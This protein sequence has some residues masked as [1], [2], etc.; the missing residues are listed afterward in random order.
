MQFKGRFG[1]SSEPSTTTLRRGLPRRLHSYSI[2]SM[3]RAIG[4][5]KFPPFR[6]FR[7]GFEPVPDKPVDLAEVHL[8]TGVNGT[9]KTRIL[10]ALAALLGNPEPLQKRLSEP[11]QQIDLAIAANPR[12]DAVS[13]WPGHYR[14]RATS[15]S[16][17]RITQ[18][19]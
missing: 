4:S 7:L 6:S 11:S 1:S 13:Q 18:E 2:L 14:Q 3:F 16:W 15:T 19:L 9:G 12:T 17:T 10:S 5:D 8:L